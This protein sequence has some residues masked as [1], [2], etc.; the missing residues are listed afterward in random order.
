M[1]FAENDID[2]MPDLH[3]SEVVTMPVVI[4][5][6][7]EFWNPNVMEDTDYNIGINDSPLKQ[8]LE[9]NISED[10]KEKQKMTKVKDCGSCVF[11]KVEDQYPHDYMVELYG[12]LRCCGDW[13][14]ENQEKTMRHLIQKG[15]GNCIWLCGNCEKKDDKHKC[16]KMFCNL[17]YFKYIEKLSEGGKIR[18]TRRICV[19][20]TNPIIS[21]LRQV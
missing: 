2:I 9:M 4:D 12:D 7:D 1:E 11:K 6:P 5:N 21:N 14:C 13:K 3:N 20:N 10:G 19:E 15:N 17:C 18:R 8:R 16:Q